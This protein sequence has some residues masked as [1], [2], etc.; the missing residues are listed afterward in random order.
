M[1]ETELDKRVGCDYLIWHIK[2]SQLARV[3]R[4]KDYHLPV[5]VC[6]SAIKRLERSVIRGLY[7]LAYGIL[8]VSSFPGGSLLWSITASHSSPTFG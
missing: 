4:G 3:P 1:I 7:E 5:E 2:L 6:S 8:C